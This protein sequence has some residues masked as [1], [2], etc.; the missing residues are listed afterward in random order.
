MRLDQP[1]AGS[2][3]NFFFL[4]CAGAIDSTGT[5]GAAEATGAG[6]GSPS[7]EACRAD[8]KLRLISHCSAVS[9]QRLIT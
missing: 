2:I 4:D 5:M 1:F 8:Q 9:F 7:T 3:S 6:L